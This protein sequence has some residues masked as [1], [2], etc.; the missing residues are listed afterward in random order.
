MIQE[1]LTIMK[2][3]YIKLVLRLVFVL[4]AV[5][6][7]SRVSRDDTRALAGEYAGVI[8]SEETKVGGLAEAI[9]AVNT[10]KAE[11]GIR[12]DEA[13]EDISQIAKS[14]EGC[15]ANGEVYVPEDEFS[16]DPA[17]TDVTAVP[18][19]EPSESISEADGDKTE[20]GT[21]QGELLGESDNPDNDP[22]VI[23]SED[24][25]A[26]GDITGTADDTDSAST[27][28]EE[29]VDEEP[30]YTGMTE[31]E[32][33]EIKGSRDPEY[34][35]TMEYI[36]ALLITSEEHYNEAIVNEALAIP[37]ESND[38]RYEF[39]TGKGY[40]AYTIYDAPE[41]FTSEAVAST[42]MVTFDVPVWKMNS[43][44]KRYS[45]TW[46]ITVNRKLAASVRCIFSD[47]YRLD[48]K[49]PFNYL[50]G[51]MYRKVGGSGLVNSKLLSIHSFGAAIDIN[52]WDNDNDY[53]LGKGN[54]LRN[55]DNP[56]CIPQEVIDIFA[57]YGWYWG[58]DFE[59]C[60]DS[61]HFQYYGLEFLQYDSDEPFPI[62]SLGKE[63]MKE[64]YIQNLTQRLVKL[65]YLTAEGKEFTEEVDAAVK[66]FQTDYELEPD[67]I[68][69]YET[70]VPLINATHDM[71]YV[72]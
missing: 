12:D 21:E 37:T 16:D 38:A 61:M 43:S 54:D 71:S 62:L 47:I 9:R 17:E 1:E 56:Y 29:P 50:K 26:D 22:A 7:V 36:N 30:D 3:S 39:L 34:K 32:I 65:G 53:Y 69:D 52:F 60:V 46:S 5:L 72:F 23:L 40:K 14:D 59:I 13:K 64:V 42:Q 24:T 25:P 27:I 2:N 55:K 31:L 8:S 28:G 18:S 45:S 6:L 20:P 44:G 66:A 15:D 67:G 58:G 48:I 57:S 4:S 49:F 51:F 35:K 68:L 70:W 10:Q 11:I 33:A 63:K 41:G 19:G